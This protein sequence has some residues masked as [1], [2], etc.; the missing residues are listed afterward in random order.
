LNPVRSLATSGKRG[1]ITGGRRHGWA[2]AWLL[3]LSRVGGSNNSRPE[4]LAGAAVVARTRSVGGQEVGLRK[5]GY[6]AADIET[7][8]PTGQ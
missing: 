7:T 8:A 3:E 2:C 5:S 4:L 6:W 1:R